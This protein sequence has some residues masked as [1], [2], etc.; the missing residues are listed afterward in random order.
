[1]L[2]NETTIAQRLFREK[3]VQTKFQRATSFLQFNTSLFSR[4]SIVCNYHLFLVPNY[5]RKIKRTQMKISAARFF[6]PT[7]KNIFVPIG[8]RLIA[9]WLHGKS[10]T[11]RTETIVDVD[12][13]S[14]ST[15]TPPRSELSEIFVL[16]LISRE[17]KDSF[18]RTEDTC[19]DRESRWQQSAGISISDFPLSR[20]S[21]TDVPLFFKRES[22]PAAPSI[23]RAW[24][25]DHRPTRKREKEGKNRSDVPVLG[26]SRE[27]SGQSP[28]LNPRS[29]RPFSF[30]SVTLVPFPLAPARLKR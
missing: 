30:H 9:R 26:R 17:D 1:M 7:H 27:I 19:E 6:C 8:I 10:P 29:S 13:K 3:F 22:R 21:S 18:R 4:E 16:A 23:E 15:H 25:I 14:L 2:L 28:A 20:S 12:S 5:R 24:I 11:K